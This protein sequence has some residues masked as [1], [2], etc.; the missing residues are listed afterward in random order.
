MCGGKI[1]KKNFL[2]ILLI[3]ETSVIVLGMISYYMGHFKKNDSFQELPENSYFRYE[4]LTVKSTEN[5]LFRE[6]SPDGNYTLVIM[7]VG[8]PGFSFGT[9]QLEVTL[10][11]MIPESKSPSK[12][13]RVSF[14]ATVANDGARAE[15]KVEWLDDGV[16]IA[17]SGEE[18][19]TAYY[20][21]PFKKLIE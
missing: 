21:L 6:L 11:E 20:V 15:Y 5:E 7:A 8:E 9:D 3:V 19:P 2:V 18:Q 1:M 12:Y 17:L 16:Q 14:R 4:Y 10:F 13:Y